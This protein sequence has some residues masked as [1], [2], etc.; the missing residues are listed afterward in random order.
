MLLS[1]YHGV[2]KLLCIPSCS[3]FHSSPYTLSCVRIIARH[4]RCRLTRHCWLLSTMNLMLHMEASWLCSEE[5]TWYEEGSYYETHQVHHASNAFEGRVSNVWSDYGWVGGFWKW[6]VVDEVNFSS[7]WW[8]WK[9]LCPC[10]HIPWSGTIPGSPATGTE[11]PFQ[12]E[13]VTAS[14]AARVRCY[15]QG[16]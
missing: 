12:P 5:N 7:L 15:W 16:G 1:N 6:E 2:P 3:W 9:I 10:V 13:H 8:Y 4:C 11:I 14:T